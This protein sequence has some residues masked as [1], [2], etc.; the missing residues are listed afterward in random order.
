M[1]SLAGGKLLLECEDVLLDLCGRYGTGTELS[2]LELELMRFVT[3]NGRLL[4]VE[5][6]ISLEGL[7][8][9]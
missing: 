3:E 5:L 1:L 9:I 6:D 2:Q 4:S 8:V 7:N